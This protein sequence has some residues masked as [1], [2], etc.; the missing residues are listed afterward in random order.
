MLPGIFVVS[1]GKFE[2]GGET[3]SRKCCVAHNICV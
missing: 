1:R 3:M 2:G